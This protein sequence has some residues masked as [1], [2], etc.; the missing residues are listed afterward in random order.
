MNK[1]IIIAEVGECFNGDLRAARKL[2]TAA[3]QA[4]CD[5]V[6]FQTLDREAISESDPEKEWFKK[7]SLDP[8]DIKGLVAYA[9]RCGIKILFTPENVKTAQW[10][11]DQGIREAKIASTLIHDLNLV[12]F[13]NKNFKRIFISTGMASL[14]E[15]KRAV[16][17]LNN[18]REL[19]IM[20]CISEYP[21]GPLLKKRG[22]AAL[23]PRDVR[24]NMMM[25]LMDAFPGK[26][27]GYSDHTGGMLAPVAAVAMGAKVIEKHITLDRETPVRNFKSGGKYLGTDHVLSLEPLELKE[28]V[29]EIREVESMLGARKWERSKGEKILRNFLI[30][31]FQ[32]VG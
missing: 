4:G 2:I 1:T 7:V 30:G 13:L 10:L 17:L 19:Y 21:T 12:R 9:K 6:K 28:M 18:I 5:Y 20:H 26:P 23:S 14:S 31:R 32:R 11:L 27:V 3:S 15:V 29:R 22:L 8:E 24:L 25:I 16:K